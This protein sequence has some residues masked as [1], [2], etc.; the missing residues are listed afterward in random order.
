MGSGFKVWDL[1]VRISSVLG[2]VF[3]F[4][5]GSFQPEAHDFI[6][7]GSWDLVSR[8]ISTLIKAISRHM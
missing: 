7:G 3:F 5:F 4:G 8:V 6:L 2:L 1:K